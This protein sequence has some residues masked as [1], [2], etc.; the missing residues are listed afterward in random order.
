M[1]QEKCQEIKG[2]IKDDFEIL[3]EKNEPLGDDRP[4]D[5]ETIVFNGPL[6]K[7][8]LLFI[9]HPVVLE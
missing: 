5:I 6:G 3:E 9:S 7:I 1:N 2:R 4:G 8:K